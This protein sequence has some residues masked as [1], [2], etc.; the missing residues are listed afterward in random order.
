MLRRVL[1]DAPRVTPAVLGRSPVGAD[2]ISEDKEDGETRFCAT[3]GT[4]VIASG[5]TL[6]SFITSAQCPWSRHALELL[7][8]RASR[9][10]SFFAKLYTSPNWVREWYTDSF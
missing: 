6:P 4:L 9:T 1:V 8:E 3:S 10:I 5:G 7:A 2:V